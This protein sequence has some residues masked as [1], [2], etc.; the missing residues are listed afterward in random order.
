LNLNEKIF[1]RFATVANSLKDIGELVKEYQY[2]DDDC[3]ADEFEQIANDAYNQLGS[4]SARAYS[5]KE[6]AKRIEK[7]IAK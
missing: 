1:D 4:L 6:R 2:G 5:L 7:Q 3:V